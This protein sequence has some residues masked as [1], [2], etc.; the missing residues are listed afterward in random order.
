MI[1][2]GNPL[3]QYQAH[4]A[5]ID[6]AIQKTLDKGWYILGEET[7]AFENEFAS[8]VG[9][10]YGI[11]VGNGTDALRLALAACGVTPVLIHAPIGSDTPTAISIST[12][13]PSVPPTA[14]TTHVLPTKTLRPTVKLS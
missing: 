6:A 8:Y 11:G 14:A 7:R 1:L 9:K 3:A 10:S 2:C 4:K 13:S 12:T 5:E